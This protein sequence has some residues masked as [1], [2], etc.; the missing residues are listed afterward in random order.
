MSSD[1]EIVQRASGQV[2]LCAF[3]TVVLHMEKL[4]RS[5][6]CKNVTNVQLNEP[7]QCTV[8]GSLQDSERTPM[9]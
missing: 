9:E 1:W 3:G 4:L 8:N 7:L 6:V 2:A 5:L